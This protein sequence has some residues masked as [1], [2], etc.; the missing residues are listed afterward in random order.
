MEKGAV[1][2]VNDF[3]RRSFYNRNPEGG[4]G[5]VVGLSTSVEDPVDT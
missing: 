1:H 5:A 3:H 2:V 4:P